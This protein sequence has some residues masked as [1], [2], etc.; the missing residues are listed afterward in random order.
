MSLIIDV[1]YSNTSAAASYIWRDA[2]FKTIGNIIPSFISIANTDLVR[3]ETNHWENNITYKW[4]FSTTT[5]RKLRRIVSPIGKKFTV[6]KLAT[7]INNR[8]KVDITP[9]MVSDGVDEFGNE[10]KKLIGTWQLEFFPKISNIN[11]SLYDVMAV[12]NSVNN[13]LTFHL[14]ERIILPEFGS[15]LPRI[16][17]S[18]ITDAQALVIKEQIKN[19]LGWEPRVQIIDITINN[20]PDEYMIQIVITYAIPELNEQRVFT[21]YVVKVVDSN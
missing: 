16:V 17:G 5:D 19:M 18:A 20:L 8:L 10:L 1:A 13:L 15:V 21:E 6:D 7:S 12:K 14:G 4:Y 2:S 9:Y 11:N 3:E